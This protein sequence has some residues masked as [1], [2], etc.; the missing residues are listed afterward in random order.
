VK[1]FVPRSRKPS[2]I[3]SALLRWY[4]VH[5]RTLPWRAK[6]GSRPNPYHVL[7][8]EFM[9]QQTGVSTVIP[10]FQKFIRRW[11][12]IAALAKADLDEVR[13]Q[14]AGLGY[15]RRASFLHRC[16]QAIVKQHGGHMPAAEKELLALPGIG[17]YTAAAL[18]A[19]AF[20]HPA[21]VV[22]GNVERVVARLYAYGGK[23]EGLKE[24]AAPLVPQ[25]RAGDYAQALM[26]LGA[27][28][29]TPRNPE[30]PR[31][32]LKSNCAALTEGSPDKYPLKI[33]KKPVPQKY[34]AVFVVR[35]RQGRVLLRKRPETGIYAGLWEF[36]STPW[37][38]KK[39]DAKRVAAHAP[40]K[41]VWREGK[42]PVSQVFS[43][44]RLHFSLR[45]GH[46][47]AAFFPQNGKKS[48]YRW[49][50]ISEFSTLALPSVM[51]KVLRAAERENDIPLSSKAA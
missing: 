41:L 16:A 50:K 43:H 9:L 28:L 30:C 34:A 18:A 11:P 4:D 3:A 32:P 29:C 36:P 39:P 8:S 13:T 44:F 27:T 21:N 2:N 24:L 7:L 45:L 5:G 14:W 22:D 25:N 47:P 10:Y 17:P 42:Y 35:D 40:R 1:K 46:S 31:C 19:I 38:L 26:D 49:I 23:R 51:H 37:E 48:E 20:D 15:Y 12:T 6:G 33:V